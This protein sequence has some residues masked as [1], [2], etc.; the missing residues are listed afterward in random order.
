MIYLKHGR[1]NWWPSIS[2][3][4]CIEQ[5]WQDLI[6]THLRWERI[7]WWC[8]TRQKFIFFW[9]VFD[10]LKK[11][12]NLLYLYQTDI[13]WNLKKITNYKRS[14]TFTQYFSTILI[15]WFDYE[16]IRGYNCSLIKVIT[17]PVGVNSFLT[18]FFW[19]RKHNHCDWFAHCYANWV[20][21]QNTSAVQK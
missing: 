17:T 8:K 5:L 2:I 9:L 1:K 18:W 16:E 20:V 21:S 12:I 19:R 13:S 14:W 6:T 15:R 4:K 11:K 7:Q 10:L 3:L